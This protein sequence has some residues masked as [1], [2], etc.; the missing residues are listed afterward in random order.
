LR[1]AFLLGSVGRQQCDHSANDDDCPQKTH[2]NYVPLLMPES[3][4]R[5]QPYRSE[6]RSR[7]R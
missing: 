5:H 6:S 1:H 7:N 3:I 2:L 4:D